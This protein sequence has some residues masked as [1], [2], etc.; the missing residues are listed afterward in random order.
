MVLATNG[1]LLAARDQRTSDRGNR[2]HRGHPDGSIDVVAD[3]SD[4]RRRTALELL[5]HDPQ[6][7]LGHDPR[8][9]PPELLRLLRGG[10]RALEEVAVDACGDSRVCSGGVGTK[11]EVG[12][13]RQIS[14]KI[15]CRVP[16][17]ETPRVPN[18]RR[19]VLR[20][21][22]ATRSTLAVDLDTSE[23]NAR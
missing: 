23:K 22:M 1:A 20:C 18:L 5:A 14:V 2:S 3:A 15:A 12:Q 16:K 21:T 4:G 19:M 13:H 9:A 7:C 11:N 8:V 17:T 10:K 6:R